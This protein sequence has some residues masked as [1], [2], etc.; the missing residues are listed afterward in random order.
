MYQAYKLHYE[1]KLAVY[2]RPEPMFVGA[3][4]EWNPPEAEVEALGETEGG[5][6]GKEKLNLDQSDR[7]AGIGAGIGWQEETWGEAMARR[8]ISRWCEERV[9]QMGISLVIHFLDRRT[10]L[11]FS[12]DLPS[13]K[14]SMP[15]KL[16]SNNKPIHLDNKLVIKTA[17]PKFFTNLLI[18][19]T[20]S[21]WL[22]LAPE[23]LTSISSAELLAAFFSPNPP[24]SP[25]KSITTNVDNDIIDHWTQS[26][27]HQYLFFL[28]SLSLIAP[29]PH[30]VN[31]AQNSHFTVSS[32]ASTTTL[33]V[34]DRLRILVVVWFHTFT[35][36]LEER[37]LR[38]LGAKFVEGREPWKIYERALGRLDREGRVEVEK[39]AEE[40]VGSILLG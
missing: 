23:L 10:A 11:H 18:S 12:G 7:A 25:P 1:R 36:M 27:R 6:E 9:K 19:P 2:P 3:E 26:R 28:F 31:Y 22:V 15:A 17:D 39:A 35:E 24:N 13:N 14:Q 32:A 33:S 5:K 21:H 4:N 16:K 20:P 30:L 29:L 37:L 40:D 8:V 34:A 38:A